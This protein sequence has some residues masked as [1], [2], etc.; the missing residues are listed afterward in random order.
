MC[1]PVA[2][3]DGAAVEDH[4]VFQDRPL[5]LADRSELFQQVGELGRVK[6]ID[7]AKPPLKF[8]IVAVVR[9]FVMPPGRAYEIVSSGCSLRSP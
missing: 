3:G 4:R 9:Q 7:L 1:V 2:I 5:P 6:T 8:R